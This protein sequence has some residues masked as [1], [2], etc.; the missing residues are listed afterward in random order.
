LRKA[1]L[2]VYSID[3]QRRQAVEDLLV[4]S[5]KAAQVTGARG[6]AVLIITS[7]GRTLVKGAGQLG[8]NNAMIAELFRAAVRT[9]DN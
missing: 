9:A 4:Q 3:R 7:D 5:I 8:Q 6:A 2:N 1:K